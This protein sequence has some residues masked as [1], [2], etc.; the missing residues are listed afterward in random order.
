M[1]TAAG[2]QVAREVHSEEELLAM[3][4]VCRRVQ[5]Q[6]SAAISPRLL[7]RPWQRAFEERNVSTYEFFQQTARE[8]RHRF[9][10]QP[11]A[12][13]F[14]PGSHRRCLVV[15]A[16]AAAPGG[17]TCKCESGGGVCCG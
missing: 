16:P 14:W 6:S 10:H 2:P 11:G 4:Q 17:S 5:V 7:N 12:V 8:V 15:G 13:P 1:L 9:L 3:R